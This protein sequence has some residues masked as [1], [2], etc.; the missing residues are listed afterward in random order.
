MAAA[1]SAKVCGTPLAAPAAGVAAV[2][3]RAVAWPEP[4]RRRRPARPRSAPGAAPAPAADRPRRTASRRAPPRSARWR[5]SC[6][7]CCLH[8]FV[9]P[10]ALGLLAVGVWTLGDGRGKVGDELAK[11]IAQRFAAADEHVVMLGLEVA[12]RKPS[13]P[14][15]RRRLMRLRSGE[16]PVFLV[17]VKPDARRSASSPAIACSEKAE[18]PARL[19]RAALRN[20]ARLVRR[21]KRRVVRRGR[22]R[23]PRLRPRAS[24]G[25]ARGAG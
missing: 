16:L 15:R 13:R 12:A 7:G 17:T 22:H 9:V 3:G 10:E 24:C 1:R 25:R 4:G 5:G 18:R 19:P 2:A 11:G 20:C 14:A 8:S 6:C 21:R 23:G